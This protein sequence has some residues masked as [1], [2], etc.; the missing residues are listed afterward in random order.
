MEW[1]DCQVDSAKSI[2]SLIKYNRGFWKSYKQREFIKKQMASYYFVHDEPE[3]VRN[4]YGVT[5]EEGQF[6][7]CLE[8]TIRWADY[9]RRSYRRVGYLFVFD[10]F[11]VVA[12]YK[13]HF[14]Y[15]DRY[16][17]S[18]INVG[19]SEQ[20][21]SRDPDAE[22]PVLEKPEPIVDPSQHLGT[23]GEWLETEVTI[24]G[25]RYVGEGYYGPTFKTTMVDETGNV[26]IYWG[27]MKDTHPDDCAGLKIMLRAK[28]KNH[29][30]YKGTKQTIVGYAKVKKF[31]D[32]QHEGAMNV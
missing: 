17:S 14:V 25:I 32:Q 4:T 29:D 31:I 30:E 10:D 19:R 16:G 11:G 23:V 21:W 22:L 6:A 7:W 8:G 2:F 1:T 20:V 13:L 27:I 18:S 24:K 12:Q 3:N 15:D 28:V 26:V 9:G 5:M